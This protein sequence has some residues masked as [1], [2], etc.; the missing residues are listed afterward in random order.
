MFET[1]NWLLSIHWAYPKLKK[2]Y[3]NLMLN[4]SIVKHDPIYQVDIT[5][6][7]EP[8][9]RKFLASKG[10]PLRLH[11]SVLLIRLLNDVSSIFLT[12]V[13]FVISCEN[14]TANNCLLVFSTSNFTVFVSGFTFLKLNVNSFLIIF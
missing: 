10:I 11:E 14:F 12:K 2:T 7:I 3:L 9:N 5:Q 6:L 1:F 4:L 13:S 8:I